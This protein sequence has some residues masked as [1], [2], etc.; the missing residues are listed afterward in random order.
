MSR[1]DASEFDKVPD[2][3]KSSFPKTANPLL[4]S[5]RSIS[6][7]LKQHLTAELT[8]KEILR[9]VDKA[10]PSNAHSL[11]TKCRNRPCAIPVFD[12]ERG[13]YFPHI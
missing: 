4:N 12:N 9:I 3:V 8:A 13:S 11:K 2:F 7:T 5:G 1:A 10:W 6:P